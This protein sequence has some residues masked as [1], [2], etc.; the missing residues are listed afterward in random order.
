MKGKLAVICL[1]LFVLCSLSTVCAE[2]INDTQV[3][4]EMDMADSL[5]VVPESVLT[6]DSSELNSLIRNAAE[7]STLKLNKSYTPTA[8]ISIKQGKKY[9]IQAWRW[10]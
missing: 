2:N 7:G 3:S 1:L 6:D 5:E 10:M 8:Y 9:C 4:Q